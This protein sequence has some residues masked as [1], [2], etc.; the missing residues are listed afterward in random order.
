VQA[1]DRSLVEN[2]SH[3]MFRPGSRN[4][5]PSQGAATSR[6]EIY[7]RYCAQVLGRELCMCK[8]VEAEVVALL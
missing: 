6:G 2:L 3:G 1:H 5:D 4:D 7:R 8:A